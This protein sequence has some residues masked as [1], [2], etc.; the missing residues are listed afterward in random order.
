MD[1]IFK[2][3]NL[4]EI[5]DKLCVY[6][7]DRNIFYHNSID[8]YHSGEEP[9]FWVKIKFYSRFL[10]LILWTVKSGLSTLFPDK[11]SLTPLIDFTILYGKQAILINAHIFTISIVI[12]SA[13]LVFV[14]YESQNNLKVFDIVVDLKAR[15]HKYKV[16]H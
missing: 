4:D 16:R 11:L 8:S 12:L 1:R 13:K 2:K 6:A 5:L 15:K 7:F 10:V 9:S 14:Y 3:V